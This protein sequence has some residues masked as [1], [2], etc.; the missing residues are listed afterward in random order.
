[1]SNS[2][3]CLDGREAALAA[4]KPME[5]ER[6]PLQEAYGRILAR[7][8]VAAEN[9]PPFDRSPYDGYAFRSW[10]V[11][12]AS[13]D[14]PVTLKILEEI[15]AGGISHVPVTEGTAVK[16]LTGAPIPEGA[17]A[18][19]MFEKT[20][21]TE[22]TVTIFYPAKCGSNIVRTGEDVRQGAVLAK[23]GTIIDPGLVGTLA[24]QNIPEPEVYKVPKVGIISTGSEL[25]DV[26]STLTPGKIY[27]SNCHT[28]SAVLKKLGCMPVNFGIAGDQVEKISHLIDQALHTCDALILTGGVSVGDYDLTP[29]A[30]EQSG[31]T[32]LFR[33]VNL[34]PGMACAYGMNDG[35][36]ICGLS[37]N[38]AS[39]L[40][41]FYAVALPAF[42]KL[43]G[44]LNH[45]P[46]EIEVTLAQAFSK[47]SPST[48]LL[49]GRL[50][51]SSGTAMMH[52]P[53]DQGNVVLSSSIG[54]D[55]MA[56]VP[57]GSGPLAQGTKLKGFLL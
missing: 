7:D 17:D 53:K 30:M 38:P 3:S 57:A 13:L 1:M 18:V 26:G 42:R 22:D 15:P 47:K 49:R 43:C 28:L 4:V 29:A 34:K 33:G 14:H 50:D 6:I 8:L 44:F 41:N 23:A 20:V 40:T 37:G 46:E 5:T 51:L 35:K 32:L 45:V 48:R 9:V 11:R 27:N 54:C 56:I 21:F 36:L 2:I 16:V 12:E 25:V 39:S 10:D 52:L 24:A 19:T 31:V 55:V